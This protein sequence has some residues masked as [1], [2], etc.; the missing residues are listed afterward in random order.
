MPLRRLTRWTNSTTVEVR[1]AITCGIDWAENHHDVALVDEAGK[2]VAKRRISDDAEG[3]RQLLAAAGRGGRHRAGPDPGRDRDRARPADLMPARD[4][5]HGVLDQPDGGGPLSRAAPRSRGR[6]PITRT[7]WRWRTSCAPTPTCTGRCRPTPSWCRRSPCWP[8]R[9]R[10]RCGTAD[11]CPTSCA[12]TS[13][14][15]SRPRWPRSRSAASA[16]TPARPAPCSPSRRTRPPR[17]SSPR[18]GWARCCARPAGN[19]TSR[20]GPT[21]LRGIF[22]ADYLH[23]LP[24]VETAMGRQ[25]L[26]LVLQLDAACRAADD[27]AEAAAEAFAEHPDA[28]ILDQLPRYRPAHR[29]PGA[30]RDRRRP[31]P[32]PRRTRAEVLRRLS[33]D[34]RRHRQEPGRATTARSRTSGSPRPATCGSSARCPHPRSRNTTTAAAPPATGTPRRCATC[35]T[36]CWAASTTAC[37]P[38]RP[39]TRPKPSRSPNPESRTAAA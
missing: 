36:G 28:A 2:L 22:T 11:S 4:R 6:S 21:R 32:V 5:A 35:S 23:Q 9:S 16:W 38:A 37:R 1:L 17:R 34:H 27:L 31:R 20:P 15:T 13:S 7:R 29:R 12:R 10:T 39:S 25:T 33:A 18:P 3:Y 30:R 14:S 8:A 26:A 24:L 19:A